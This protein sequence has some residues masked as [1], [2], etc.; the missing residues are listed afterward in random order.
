ML[1]FLHS[2]IIKTVHAAVGTNP[3]QVIG[4]VKPPVPN[5]ALERVPR[6]G[7][8]GNPLYG[9]ISWGL[10]F[11][12][13]A[14]GVYALIN[15]VMAGAQLVMG[16]GDSA[17]TEKIRKHVTGTLLGLGVLVLAYT[18]TTIVSTIIFGDPLYYIRP[19]F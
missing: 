9:F 15:L 19:T 7:T 16:A 18:I 4:T 2:L 3:N 12:T 6:I 14:C 13:I 11:I 5:E 8:E 17:A 1:N 10:T